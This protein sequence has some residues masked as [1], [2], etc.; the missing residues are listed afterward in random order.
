[1]NNTNISNS[2]VKQQRLTKAER[3]QFSLTAELKSILVGL[4]LGDLYIAKLKR[5]VNPWLHFKQSTVNEEYLLHLYELFKIYCSSGPKIQI[6]AIDKRTGKSYS[7]IYFQTYCL[8]CFKELF[9][10]FYPDGKKIVPLN[11]G[12]LLNPLGLCFLI[13][14]DGSFCKVRSI[15]TLCTES[16]TLEEVTLLANTLNTKWDLKCYINKTNNG[17]ARILIPK[18]SVPAVQSLLKDIMPSMM[19]HKIG[20]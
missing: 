18:K 4:L 12:D 17:A 10:L 5:N 14:D 19:R 8:P 2:L 16:F 15:I 13:C 9:D 1:M 6:G 7:S 11:I 20:L 3:L